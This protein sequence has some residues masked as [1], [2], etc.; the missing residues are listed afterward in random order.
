MKHKKETNTKRRTRW[1]YLRHDDE[2]RV[3]GTNTKHDGNTKRKVIQ[4]KMYYYCSSSGQDTDRVF[5]EVES[6]LD[7]KHKLPP[8]LVRESNLHFK[9]HPNVVP[10][11]EVSVYEERVIRRLICTVRGRSLWE[12]VVIRRPGTRHANNTNHQCM[13]P[14]LG[15][16]PH[17]QNSGHTIT[18]RRYGS[19]QL[20]AWQWLMFRTLW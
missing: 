16:D 11:A 5:N 8:V 17:S 4:G 20:C 1:I 2:L 13:W 14:C 15:I 3:V 10:S 7:G 9:R 19:T 12:K 18:T 6:S